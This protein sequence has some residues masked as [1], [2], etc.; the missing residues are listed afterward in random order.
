MT[1]S[2]YRP[3]LES[4][5]FVQWHKMYARYG[6]GLALTLIKRMLDSHI[7]SISATIVMTTA[8]MTFY[9]NTKATWFKTEKFFFICM[10][11]MMETFNKQGEDNALNAPFANFTLEFLFVNI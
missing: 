9:L 11:V 1:K 2:I 7:M 6:C 3:A 10:D 8:K 4:V 5:V